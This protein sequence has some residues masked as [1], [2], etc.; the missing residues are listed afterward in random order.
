MKS[1]HLGRRLLVLVAA[2][3]VPVAVV[4][5]IAMLAF[6]QQQ[7]EHAQRAGLE[8][9]RALATAVDAE[10]RRTFSVLEVLA[11][12]PLLDTDDLAAFLVRSQ[13][14]LTT[15]PHW[16]V[17]N[18]ALPD[19]TVLVNTRYPTGQQPPIA[20]T[21]SF[22]RAVREARPVVG[23]LTRGPRGVWAVAIRAPVERAGKVRYVLTAAVA[24]DSFLELVQRQR[25]PADW[26]VSI[27]DSKG[28]RIAR[29]RDAQH[30]AAQPAP[31]LKA[32][33]ESGAPEGAGLTRTLEGERIHTAFTRL[34]E[35]RWTI[36]VG[37][38]VLFLE[39]A[40]WR[41]LGVFGGGVL[42]SLAIGLW[43]ALRLGRSINLPMAHLEG[44]ANALGRGEPVHPPSTDIRE[45][46]AVANALVVSS[47]RRRRHEAEREELL[48]REQS[49]RA[50]AEAANKSKD[51]FLAMLGHEL[52]NPLGAI[53]NAA[54]LV[55]NPRAPPEARKQA[56][57][58][59]VRQV[60]HL[61]RLT[62]DL[63]DAARALT[64]K[65]VLERQ[66]VD[67]AG[68]AAQALRTL[69]SAGRTQKHE[70]V[71]RLEPVWV[72]ADP[73]R[74]DQI[75]SNLV[76]NAVKYTPAAGTITVSV[77]REGD[78]AVVRVADTGIGLSPDLAGRVF[79]LFVQGDRPLD[80]SLGGLGIGLTLVRRLAEMHGGTVSVKSAGPGEGSEFSVRFPAI[81]QP[82]AGPVRETTSPELAP[83]SVLLV[84]DNEDA[85]ETLEMLLRL[86][87]HEVQAEGDGPA[88]LR[89]ALELRPDIM[90]VDIGL[91]MMDG[92]EVAR[93]IRQADGAQPYLVAITGYGAPEDRQRAIDAGFDAHVVKPVDFDAL[94]EVLRRAS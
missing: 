74:V 80:R 36:A 62:D 44:A 1:T 16:R 22:Q 57:E 87:G 35:P 58:V 86:A 73:I 8:I 46:A 31:S 15:Q 23:D 88:G 51:E 29:S 53:S 19:G 78:E 33:M 65:I 70:I 37:I 26:V 13:R 30:F 41:S 75:V 63:L 5:G 18:L 24:P 17:I 32:L 6:F 14:S 84:E 45:I 11:S 89:R 52:R 3:I 42:L 38:P 34:V 90:L 79:D 93:R 21:P 55:D 28:Q 54:G 2:A 69:K 56:G 4:S 40:A 94:T 76:V 25:V 77:A 67:L 68:I 81:E 59:I 71:E 27:F 43:V 61:T 66:P 91:P 83:R 64:G 50:F 7:R 85:R 9:S 82:D 92:Y 48:K 10:I 60:G 72:D 49:A 47:E 39:G 12:S 20:D